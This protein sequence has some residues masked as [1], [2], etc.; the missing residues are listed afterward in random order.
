MHKLRKIFLLVAIN[1]V[2][3]GTVLLV[4]SHNTNSYESC[5]DTFYTSFSEVADP[6]MRKEIAQSQC[7]VLVDK[8]RISPPVVAH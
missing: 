3:C 5:V 1:A 2:L 7:D 8:G 6:K 4:F